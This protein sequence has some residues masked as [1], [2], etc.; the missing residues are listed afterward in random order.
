M[1]HTIDQSFLIKDLSIQHL[2][3]IGLH[4]V[5]ITPVMHIFTD[6]IHH[7][8]N[9]DV[10]TAMLWS[11]QGRHCRSDGRICIR[12]GR[13]NHTGGKRTVITAAM[14]HM[15]H[16]CHIK[17]LCLQLCIL[18]IRPQHTKEILCR[19]KLRVRSV[20][21]HT[22]I[23]FIMIICVIS[24]YRDHREIGNQ[25]HTLTDIVLNGRICR[26]RIIGRKC[27]NTSCHGI[28]DI[29]RRRLHNNV[30]GKI[31]RKC[32]A[33][34]EHLTEFIQLRLIRKFSK[35]QQIRRFLEAEFVRSDG[36]DQCFYIIS[37]IP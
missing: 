36:F 32:P 37:A 28:H 8:H 35:Q 11:F 2:S 33:V 26:I 34:A 23:I 31:G 6:I 10:G 21:I 12:T 20:N 7:L 3:K 14:L 16:Q 22:R 17:H 27:Q 5:T 9:F 18:L 15:K 13:S 24:I 1:S 4:L 30:S 19:G 25:L 29:L